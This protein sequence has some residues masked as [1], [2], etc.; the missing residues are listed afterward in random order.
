MIPFWKPQAICLLVLSRKMAKNDQKYPPQG[1]EVKN[2][3]FDQP[4]AGMCIFFI[5][6]KN[7]VFNF[8]ILSEYSHVNFW[9][10]FALDFNLWGCQK[11]KKL[12]KKQ[13]NGK[14]WKNSV[15]WQFF[16]QFC[17]PTAYFQWMIGDIEVLHPFS[18]F[19]TP[20]NWFLGQKGEILKIWKFSNL[21]H[22]WG[23]G[24]LIMLPQ[25][26][27]DVCVQRGTPDDDF[28][29]WTASVP[30]RGAELWAAKVFWRKT[31][32]SGKCISMIWIH[33]DVF[34]SPKW[35]SVASIELIWKTMITVGH[36]GGIWQENNLFWALNYLK[37]QQKKA[38]IGHTQTGPFQ[39]QFIIQ[40]AQ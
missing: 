3:K 34:I 4:H 9:V 13:K 26:Q 2:P 35:Y 25:A 20:K 37:I 31:K 36:S 28:E 1:A 16:H 32:N 23:S 27:E 39:G 33:P 30:R 40:I 19:W 29:Y 6:A 5:L 12:E 11:L 22:F 38:K 14:K 15:N 24:A 10:L 21:A 8:K 17:P 7:L 18:A